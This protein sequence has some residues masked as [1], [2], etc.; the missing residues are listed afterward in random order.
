MNTTPQLDD[1]NLKSQVSKELE[2]AKALAKSFD[3]AKVKNGEWFFTLLKQ[4]NKAYDRN[5]RAA[6]FQKKYPGLSADEIADILTSVTVRYATIAGAVAG[7]AASANEIATLG[8]GGMTVALFVGAIGAEMLYLSNIQM[9]LMLDMSVL[10]D[11]QLDPEDPEDILMV[12][13]YALGVAP[14]EII[15]KG[16]QVAARA[17][18]ESGIKKVVTNATREALVKFAQR[19]GFKITQGSIIKFAV[20]VA[21]AAVGSGY[22]YVTTRSVG[23]IA[24]LH[25]KNRGKVTDELRAAISRQNTYG[26]A[27]PAAAIFMAQVDGNVSPKEKELYRA[28][29]SRMSFEEHAPADFQRLVSNEQNILDAVSQIEDVELR[30]TLIELLTLMAIYDGI[31]A[32]E[33]REFLMNAAERLGVSLDIEEVEKR[34]KEYQII[35]EKN[36]FEKTAGAMGSTAVS[37]IG[38]AGQAATKFKDVFGKAV[39][40]DVSVTASTSSTPTHDDPVERLKRLKQMLEAELISQSEFDAKKAEILSSI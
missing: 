32:N 37:V 15:G 2:E 5:A 4:V 14:T 10:Y 17:G 27:I 33:E 8:T 28:M 18:T 30:K 21:S 13:G 26:L 16:V 6:Y 9:R 24:K 35:I 3:F 1:E 20:P 29:L 31:L 12:F 22:N 7:V 23:Q 36:V 25:F 40:R 38:T 39:K 34:T 19:L 11:L